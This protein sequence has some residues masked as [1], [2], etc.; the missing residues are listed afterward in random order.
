MSVAVSIILGISMTACGSS[1]KG[2]AVATINGK[3][4]TSSYYEKTLA[5]YKQAIESTNGPTIWDTEVEKGVKYKDQFKDMVLQQMID[6][7]VIY[8][9]AKK[10]KLLPSKEEVDKKFKELKKNIDSDEEYKKNLEKIGINDEYLKNQQEQ[11]LALQ[12][13]K[14]NFNKDIPVFSITFGDASEDQLNEIADL[15]SGKVFNG[16]KDL[17]NAFKQAKGYN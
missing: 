4:I 8:G 3:D 2:E 15:T 11:D 10:E 16:K 17:I 14:N 1:A 5:L 6:T 9:E 12:N 7:E 13:Y